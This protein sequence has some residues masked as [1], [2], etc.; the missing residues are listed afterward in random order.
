MYK[1]R[2]IPFLP[3][4]KIKREQNKRIR[5][6]IS[7]A[8]TYVPYYRRT[9]QSLRLKPENF[10]TAEDLRKL[11]LLSKRDI[12]KSP[13]DF[14]SKDVEKDSL[15]MKTSGSTGEPTAILRSQTMLANLLAMGRRVQDALNYKPR[16][17]SRKAHI[18]FQESSSTALSHYYRN[19]IWPLKYTYYQNFKMFSIFAP[20]SENY[21][22]LKKFKPQYLTSRGSYIRDL[23]N[24]MAQNNLKLPDLKVVTYTA[25]HLR[26]E[27]RK[28]IEER[29]CPVFSSYSAVET[30][31]IGFEC[32]AQ[33]GHHLN[34]DACAVDLI[35]RD[36]SPVSPG[37]E[38][39]VI[40]SNLVNEG[41][42]LLNYRLGDL[43]VMVE[44]TEDCECKRHLPLLKNLIGRI[45]DMITLRDG[46]ILNPRMFWL[47]FKKM[48]Q[49]L[50][51][52]LIQ[53]DFDTYHLSCILRN[54]NMN[55][56]DALEKILM[57]ELQR[58][59]GED[60]SI[61]VHFV[62]KIPLPPGGKPR[63]IESKITQ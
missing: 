12:Q 28:M 13:S 49:I 4:Y 32:K 6:I 53:E 7:Y 2:K 62:S 36:G 19:M 42:V 10:K 23:F 47:L 26:P 33:R 57:K 50:Q 18:S 46:T 21:Q 38:G 3:Y 5:K 27:M 60:S 63:S 15:W 16:F 17:W 24:Y 1:L 58:L 43:A 59:L 39:E 40:V 25:D 11:P 9:L 41:M 22:L 44:D 52:K 56:T 30:G 8:Y 14:I 20:P 61:K 54:R 34:I 29:F 37:K 48:N 45:D 35:G 55:E 51:Y 31:I